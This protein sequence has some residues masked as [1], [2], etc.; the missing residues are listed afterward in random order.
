MTINNMDEEAATRFRLDGRTVLVTGAGRGLGRAIALTAAA[1][2][3]TVVAVS[4]TLSDL[5]ETCAEGPT[6]SIVPLEW[7]VQ[8]IE[9]ADELVAAAERAAGPLW[10]V[11]HAAGVQ[12]RGR[13]T[14]FTPGA[15]ATVVRTNLEAPFFLSTAIHR[16][17]QRRGGAGSHVFIGSLASSIGLPDMSAYAAS[18]S[19]LLGVVRALST[20][21]APFGVR[22]NCLAPGYVRTALTEDLLTDPDRGSWVRSRIPMGRLGEPRDVAYAAVFLLADASRYITGQLL[23]VDGGWLAA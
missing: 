22:V 17:H 12:H 1:V 23:N 15:W 8:Q 14:Q 5:A 11:V 21:W 18:K 9:V 2:G 4:R 19:G 3:A 16:A 20:E 10:G 13:A 6:G 7:D